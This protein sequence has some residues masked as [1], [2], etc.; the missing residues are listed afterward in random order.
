MKTQALRYLILTLPLIW[1]CEERVDMPFETYT[2]KAGK[3]YATAKAGFLQADRLT[4]YATF[5]ETA[6]YVTSDPENQWDTNK[7]FGFAD[8][9]SHHHEHSARFG[10]RWVEGKIEILAYCYVSGTR[11]IEKIG[12]TLPHEK[13][14]Y[15][16]RLTDSQYQ[17]SFDGATLEV[18]REKPCDKGAYYLLF[19][20]FGGN[21]TAPHDIHIYLQQVY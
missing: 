7:L 2:I 15:E 6:E 10:W 12:E 16:I 11:I 8:C 14:Y 3:H 18:P 4:F 13:N 17:F 20:Y 21:E 9:N 1:S 19:P 5:D